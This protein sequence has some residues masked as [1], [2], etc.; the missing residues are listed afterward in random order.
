[1]NK[2][3]L[4][5]N[6]ISLLT[7]LKLPLQNEKAAQLRIAEHLKEN[8]ISADRE[9]YL[10]EKD[11]PDFFIDGILIE[12]KIN[13]PSRKVYEQL[14]RYSKYDQVECIILITLKPIGLPKEINS[15]PVYVINAGKAWM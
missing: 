8:N 4:I 7:D 9:F 12:V 6:L 1:M 10:S 15:K 3:D 11:I 5:A 13:Y 14:D 2:P